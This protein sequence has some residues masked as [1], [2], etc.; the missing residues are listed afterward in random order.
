[1][2]SMRLAVGFAALMFVVG[3]AAGCG[4]D[5][6]TEPSSAE[7][8]VD[9]FCTATQNWRDELQ[10]IA[11]GFDDVNSLSSDAISDAAEE[12]RTATDDYVEQVRDLGAPD[13]ES[14]DEVEQSVETLADEVDTEM[15]E[16][17]Q[18]VEGVDGLSEIV[19]AG[20]EVV[21]S[22]NSM[23]TSVQ[24]TLTAIQ[25]ADPSGE[26]RTAFDAS[27]TCDEIST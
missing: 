16:I 22:V 3:L 17:E 1:M 25:T 23:L 7:A 24:T 15:D 9:S 19:A 12:A 21:G 8:W 18:T 4:G 11:D 26:L 14:G 2:S 5:D 27:P 6:E 10:S 20:R 13:T